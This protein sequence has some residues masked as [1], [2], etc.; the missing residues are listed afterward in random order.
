MVVSEY[1]YDNRLRPQANTVSPPHPPLRTYCSARQ[2]AGFSGTH[3]KTRFISAHVNL[4]TGEKF[5]QVRWEK[6]GRRRRISKELQSKKIGFVK[7]K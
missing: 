2:L 7:E 3:F 4:D 6:E 1:Y 5:G